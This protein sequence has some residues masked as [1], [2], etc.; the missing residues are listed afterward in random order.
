[1]PSAK[2][3]RLLLTVADVAAISVPVLM[4]T[5]FIT[6]TLLRPDYNPVTQVA[7]PLGE[8]GSPY[9]VVFNTVHFLLPGLLLILHG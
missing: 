8:S 2:Y 6:V 7:S 5:A 3:Y 9:A 1:M 4:W